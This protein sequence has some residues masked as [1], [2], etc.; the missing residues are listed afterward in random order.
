[1]PPSNAGKPD[2]TRRSRPQTIPLNAPETTVLR[3]AGPA[4]P[5]PVPEPPPALA[6][7]PDASTLLQALR[8]RWMLA[9]SL[10]IIAAGLA[11]TAAFLLVLPRYTAFAQVHIDVSDSTYFPK[12]DPG[13]SSFNTFR[14]T[15][16]SRLKSR[17]VLI[18]ALKAEPVK[19]LPL[20]REQ[21][22]PLIW[23]EDEL[24]LEMPEESEITT[25]TMMGTDPDAIV[26]IVQ[27]VY[28]AYLKQVNEEEPRFKSERLNELRKVLTQKNNAIKDK[29]E[30]LKKESERLNTPDSLVIQQRLFLM[31][32]DLTALSSQWNQ[33]QVE[34]RR[35]E[36]RLKTHQAQEQAI[37]EMTVPPALLNEVLESDPEAKILLKRLANNKLFLEDW[38]RI[39]KNRTDTPYVQAKRIREQLQRDLEQRK[40]DL[41][42]EV[43]KR[44]KEKS[45]A[46]YKTELARLQIE[47]SQAAETEKS[48]G[49]RLKT[50]EEDVAKLGKSSTELELLR[51]EIEQEA[52][53]I[54]KIGT[55][56]NELEVDLNSR[57]RIQG[58]QDAG[59]QKKDLKRW[60]A[61][62]IGLPVAAFGF[63]CFGVAW[64]ESRARRVQT[65]EEVASG[66]GLRV[67]GSVPAMSG[68]PEVYEHD[69]LESI[70]AIRTL[71]LREDSV[72]ETRVVMVTSA[73][74]G[75]G[76]TTLASHLA[77]SLARAGRRTLLLDCDL[78][79]PAAHQ[80]FELPLQ[81]GFSEV[82]MNE[83]HVAEAI[84]ST[85]LDGLWL[86]PAG[87]WDRDVMQNLARGGVEDIIGRIR[88][89][90]DFIIVD[91]H[92]VLPATDSLLVG[93]H[94]DA[95]LLSLLR[96][97]SQTPRVYA[98]AQ[99]LTSL[100]IRILGAVVNGTKPDDYGG[101]YQYSAQ[102]AQAA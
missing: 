77:S 90:Y 1:V 99:R 6:A 102:P 5:A 70:D 97:V 27:A 55:Q 59:I 4:L 10:G 94:V 57:P 82:L 45:L 24:K 66:L 41:V 93:Q 98:A 47:A 38:E 95:V 62:L 100:G 19:A 89:D 58:Y 12:G 63:V 13:R 16:S 43:A 74:S 50:L 65:P 23:L 61:A 75:E 52:D 101:G 37:N 81:P 56:A 79:R 78:R 67:I 7:G 91:S 54:K 18:E 11:G 68:N 20:V 26:K 49:E 14:K 60:L 48:M 8:R 34:R 36:A 17:F 73:V 40:T 30:L 33:A 53:A 42:P 84:R 29:K 44:V 85:T 83:V 87:Q 76:K 72:V 69:L 39:T 80:L 2:P 31:R 22:D 88:A 28:A 32:S 25:L 71:L 15:Q 9:L 96:D 21:S 86:M 92:P 35:A 51:G 3:D 46:D 64:L